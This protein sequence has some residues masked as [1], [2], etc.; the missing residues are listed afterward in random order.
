MIT[1]D[2]ARAMFEE[3]INNSNKKYRFDQISEVALEEPLYVMIAIDQDGNQVFP[4]EVFP[5]IRK[6][7]GA[8]VNFSFPATG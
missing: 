1:I 6:S 8:I 2:Q 7:D 3:M 5:S 4:G